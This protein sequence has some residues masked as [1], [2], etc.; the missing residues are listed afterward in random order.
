MM[1]TGS[2]ETS[3]HLKHNLLDEKLAYHFAVTSL[4]APM[5][6]APIFKVDAVTA[7]VKIGRRNAGASL[8][9]DADTTLAPAFGGYGAS[10][11]RKFYDVT[12]L[13]RDLNSWARWFEKYQTL[14]GIPNLAAYGG[15]G[16]VEVG[17]LIRL[18]AKNAAGIATTGTYSF[19]NFKISP[20]GRLSITGSTHFWNNFY[21]RFTAYGAALL[22]FSE[23][24]HS[25]PH[26]GLGPFVEDFYIAYT[27]TAAGIQSSTQ[28]GWV[29]PANGYNILQGNNTK[30]VTVVANSPLFQIADQRVSVSVESHLPLASN[31]AIS[32][33]KETVDRKIVE[34]FFENQLECTTS[35]GQDGAFES[36]QI[37]SNVYS[38]QVAFIKKSDRHTQWHRLLTAFQL[39]YFRF[40]LSITYRVYNAATNTWYLKSEP[41]KVPDDKYWEMEV[42][43]ISD[44]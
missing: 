43:F 19:L 28:A 11:G 4:S 21:L 44:T 6:N 37:A 36:Q 40:F 26:V 10:P 25:V 29:D 9:V 13:V 5:N 14:L 2:D 32:D 35:F 1:Q 23:A 38:G 42:R 27:T 24:V 31:I 33:E 8:A 3:V 15:I 16:D 22:G 39:S 20:D 41:L 34:K 17:P 18:P 12:S 30:D 7:I